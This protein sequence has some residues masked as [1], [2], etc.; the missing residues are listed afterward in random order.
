MST[1]INVEDRLR[2]QSNA[3]KSL[4]ESQG[5]N[6]LN[7]PSQ[8]HS[9]NNTSSLHGS[10]HVNSLHNRAPITQSQIV[11]P[12]PPTPQ[13]VKE[14]VVYYSVIHNKIVKMGSRELAREH[15][16]NRTP[17]RSR[18]STTSY[19]QKHILTPTQFKEMVEG[20]RCQT[21]Q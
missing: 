1:N 16:E 19:D 18:R 12:H 14:E 11:Q 17:T 21:E 3:F 8:Y 5:G 15:R 13:T 4:F 2:S 9:H 20:L 10:M 6:H 7:P